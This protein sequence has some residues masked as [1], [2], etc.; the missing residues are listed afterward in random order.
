MVFDIF[1]NLWWKYQLYNY[2]KLIKK[3]TIFDEIV[4]SEN[5]VSVNIWIEKNI[6]IDEKVKFDQILK[7]EEK[8]KFEQNIKF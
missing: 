7:F 1:I 8:I 5:Y 2:I 4:N 6:N 3:S